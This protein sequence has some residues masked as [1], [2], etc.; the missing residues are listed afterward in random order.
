MTPTE[1]AITDLSM[2]LDSVTQADAAGSLDRPLAIEQL[3]LHR[4]NVERVTRKL[5]EKVW[6]T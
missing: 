5:R 3:D 4:R 1:Q 6:P 2:A